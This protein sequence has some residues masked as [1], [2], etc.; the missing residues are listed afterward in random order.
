MGNDVTGGSD[1]TV[2]SGSSYT[3]TVSEKAQVCQF[4]TAA[5]TFSSYFGIGL[6]ISFCS[7]LPDSNLMAF[8]IASLNDS[9]YAKYL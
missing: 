7:S 8:S 5:R 9:P 3:A 2:W 4:L 1:A 6:L